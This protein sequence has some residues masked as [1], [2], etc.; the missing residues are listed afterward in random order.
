MN[1]SASNRSSPASELNNT[2]TRTDASVGIKV[3]KLALPSDGQDKMNAVSCLEN[4]VRKEKKQ[5][6]EREESKDEMKESTND[7]DFKPSTTEVKRKRKNK[8]RKKSDD[9]N[10]EE[11]EINNADGEEMTCPKLRKNKRNMECD[12]SLFMPNGV[13]ADRETVSCNDTEVELKELKKRTKK[14]ENSRVDNESLVDEEKLVELSEEMTKYSKKESKK[15]KKKKEQENEE[16]RQQEGAEKEPLSAENQTEATE[17]DGGKE[18]RKK[19]KEKNKD[20][21]AMTVEDADVQRKKCKKSKK[22]V[23]EKELSVNEIIDFPQEH[24]TEE[25]K[26]HN[27]KCEKSKIKEHLKRDLII[28]ESEELAAHES[29]SQRKLAK[30]HAD[31]IEAV[32]PAIENT[33]NEKDGKT[34][35]RKSKKQKREDKERDLKDYGN[36][37]H[38][39][40]DSETCASSNVELED[41][42]LQPKA[43][44]QKKNSSMDSVGKTSNCDIN[45]TSTKLT[46][47]Q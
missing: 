16:I 26:L 6:Q 15:L 36:N 28:N 2:K 37:F 8:K 23:T 1:G 25:S 30:K 20:K 29:K 4:S 19:R 22:S 44:L 9:C 43:K 13:S 42:T 47:D 35:S 12:G 27:K 17:T 24:N 7:V 40:S 33:A 11:I 45:N 14:K 46:S 31:E 41:H 18:Q 34:A 38:K 39:L 21:E 10:T 3:E 32:S 5:K